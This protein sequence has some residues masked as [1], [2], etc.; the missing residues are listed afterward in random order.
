MQLVAISLALLITVT[1]VSS[2]EQYAIQTTGQEAQRFIPPKLVKI[3]LQ[4]ATGY[5]GKEHSWYLYSYLDAYRD[6]LLIGENTYDPGP[7]EVNRKGFEQ[8]IADARH[9]VTSATPEDFG[10]RR[11]TIKGRFVLEFEGERFHP[12]GVSDWRSAHAFRMGPNVRVGEIDENQDYVVECWLS[13]E[14]DGWGHRGMYR[15]EI[16]VLGLTPAHRESNDDK[17][18]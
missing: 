18:S 1:F 7:Y 2:D 11:M 6:Y 16:V 8:G 5:E 3:A 4:R 12:S 17:A 14:R 10:Y 13:P 15:R 9:A